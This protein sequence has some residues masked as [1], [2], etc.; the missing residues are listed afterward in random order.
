MP[1]S[2]FWRSRGFEHGET[3]MRWLTNQSWAWAIRAKSDL[4]VRLKSGQHHAVAKLLP[5]RGQVHLYEHVQVVGD[6]DCHL[7]TAHWSDAKEAWAVLTNLPPSLQTF[8]L[9][10]QRFGGIEPHFKDYKSA[11]FDLLRSRIRDAQAL[12]RLLMLLATA[13]LLAIHIGFFLAYLG[14]RSRLD[15]HARAWTQFLT[16]RLTRTSS[17]LL[18]ASAIATFPALPLPQSSSSR[19][20]TSKK[21]RFGLPS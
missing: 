9:Y 3:L 8:S 5:Q 16:T 1:K 14:Q 7:A 21:S 20:L 6:V 11:A 19:S 15:W 12:N 4:Q 13:Q 17:P 10:G 18:S 2:R